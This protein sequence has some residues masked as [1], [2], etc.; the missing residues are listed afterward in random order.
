MWI[1]FAP[2]ITVAA[3]SIS[4]IFM[5]ALVNGFTSPNTSSAINDT[6]GIT[7]INPL[8]TGND[9]L[10][11][12]GITSFEFSKLPWWEAMDRF[13]WLMVNF[14]AIGLMWMIVF[15][16]IKSNKI[17]EGIG[18][19]VQD[20][21]ETAFKSLPILPIA[22][23]Q[24][25]GSLTKELNRSPERRAEKLDSDAAKKASDFING[26]ENK[27]P[28]TGTTFTT[29]NAKTIVTWLSSLSANATKAEAEKIFIDNNI[30]TPDAAHI[31]THDQMYYNAIKAITDQ[32]QQA[33][34][35]KGVELIAWDTWYETMQ[36]KEANNKLNEIVSKAATDETTLNNMFLTPTSANRPIIE[37]YFT[38][39]AISGKTGIYETTLSGITYTITQ[40]KTDPKN[41]KYPVKKK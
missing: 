30:P 34:A 14:F 22:W 36:T 17:G 41:I 19:R 38:K 21:G 3:L 6:L 32:K 16:A 33:G 12:G 4:L 15:A 20:F 2:V 10:N 13:S 31:T 8:T 24:G 39:E 23:W 37:D 9:A 35:I 7:K 28:G 40:D 18:K 29:D 11:F 25:I 27:T 1:I 5:T 26:P